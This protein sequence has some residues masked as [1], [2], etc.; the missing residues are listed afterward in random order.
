MFGSTD[1]ANTEAS[2]GVPRAE[3]LD[4]LLPANTPD[5]NTSSSSSS[6]AGSA[7]E[8]AKRIERDEL[9][10][11]ILRMR[12]LGAAAAIVWTAFAF[13]DWLIAK[14]ISPVSLPQF[15]GIRAVGLAMVLY[16]AYRLRAKSKMSRAS[17]TL[18]D[19][20]IFAAIQGALSVMCIHFE[21]IASPLI[22]G[23][24]VVLVARAS[25]LACH[26][27]RG[28]IFL[29]IPVLLHPLILGGAAIF[30]PEI[31][32]QFLDPHARAVFLRHLFVLSA[33]LGVCV[34]GGH[35]NWALRRQ[36]FEARNIGRYRLKHRIGR[37]GMGEVWVAY[38]SGLKRDVALKVLRPNS[39]A[40]HVAVRRFEQEVA[41]TSRLTHP[42]TIRVFDYGVTDDG[43]WYYAMELLEG[44]TLQQ[45]VR[46][47]GPLP[48][49]RALPIA[50][51]TA[52]ALAEAH[53]RGIVHRDIKPENIAVTQAGNEPDFVKVLDFGL[54]KVCEETRGATLTQTGAVFGTPAYISPE[55]AQGKTTSRRS[56]V[57]GVGG[58]LYFMLTGHPP[59][60]A[61]N[62]AEVLMAH[63]GQPV[64]PLNSHPN[65]VVPADVSALVMRC[66]EK[67]PEDRFS[68]ASV[69]AAELAQVIMR[70]Q[71]SQAVPSK[72]A[73]AVAS[74]MPH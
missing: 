57:Y 40:N 29:G 53:A 2:L 31:R 54:A 15:L 13:D 48:L 10:S 61:A 4:V 11:D 66:L 35:G 59:F 50:H 23:I 21:G 19:I 16:F 39:E 1:S 73:D 41:A 43:I 60:E 49:A 42:N 26:W 72:A 74:P 14:F 22:T 44:I 28:L 52:R 47:H 37:G 24:L 8:Y 6:G 64:P 67:D 62:S 68:D 17:Y 69:L 12:W 20:G 25:I 33:A 3:N 7:L 36:L 45:L 27:R 46:D 34:W 56:D 70:S 38:H 9:T 58:I 32:Q 65:I 30:L 5:G 63:I 51:Q 55:A 18:H 71:T